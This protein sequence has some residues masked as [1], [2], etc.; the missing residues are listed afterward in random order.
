MRMKSKSCKILKIHFALYKLTLKVA[1]VLRSFFL[2]LGLLQLIIEAIFSK[3]VVMEIT[4][5]ISNLN[6]SRIDGDITDSDVR[7]VIIGETQLLHHTIH[8]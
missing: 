8:A 2:P 1:V 6:V 3:L 5:I 7:T 4:V